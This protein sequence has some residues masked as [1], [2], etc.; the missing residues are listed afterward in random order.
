MGFAH[1]NETENREARRSRSPVPFASLVVGAAVALW[2]TRPANDANS[3]S[4]N[5]GQTQ[6][7]LANLAQI[8]TAFVQYAH[9][10]DGKFPRGVDAEDRYNPS[11]WKNNFNARYDTAARTAPMLY[12]VL[13]PYLPRPET[14]RCPA[15]TGYTKTSLPGFELSLTNVF[16]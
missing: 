15:D 9:D 14:W 16:P 6:S 5:A 2:L 10:N 1:D 7:C 11:I 8:S 12:E 3:P 13:Q 4:S